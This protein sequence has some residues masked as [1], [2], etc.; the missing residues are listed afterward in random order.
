MSRYSVVIRPAHPADADVVRRLAH[1]DSADEL[2]GE[3]LL[4]VQGDR[5]VAAMSLTEGR[6]VADPF[7]RTA[8]AVE[9]LREH[10]DGLRT[11]RSTAR[12]AAGGL[13]GRPRPVFSG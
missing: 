13:R 11:G 3:V 9:L 10:A 7:T 5:A 12:R 8:H 6:V 2:H 1:L 4:A